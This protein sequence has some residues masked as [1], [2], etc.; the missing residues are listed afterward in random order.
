MSIVGPGAEELMLQL[1]RSALDEA[2]LRLTEEARAEL[3]QRF[4]VGAR[5]LTDAE[6]LDVD[7][8]THALGQ[9]VGAI[10]TLARERGVTE[11]DEFLVNS[12]WDGICPLF[13]FC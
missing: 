5:R 7:R 6:P 3:S 13:P 8:T 4:E 2:G 12:I 9:V 1:V 10:K 11:V